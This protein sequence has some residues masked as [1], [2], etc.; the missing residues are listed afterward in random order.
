VLPELLEQRR[1]A[2]AEQA[3]GAGDHAV[4]A[5]ER[6]RDEIGL[7]RGE[8]VLEIQARGRERQPRRLA[9]G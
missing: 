2:D 6:L 1:A 9:R 7:D 8:R 3:R 4:G 5:T